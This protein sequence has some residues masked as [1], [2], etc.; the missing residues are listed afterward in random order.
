MPSVQWP[1][2]NCELIHNSVSMIYIKKREEH[3]TAVA[4]NPVAKSCIE[5]VKEAVQ[6][7]YRNAETFIVMLSTEL[8]TQ[9]KGYRRETGH[10]VRPID[11]ASLSLKVLHSSSS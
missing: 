9:D 6:R 10:R 11:D 2:R 5:A 7:P 1:R 4:R 8:Q 3:T